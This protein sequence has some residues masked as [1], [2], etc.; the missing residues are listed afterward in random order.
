MGAMRTQTRCI[1]NAR[2]PHPVADP[3][4][5]VL[6]SSGASSRAVGQTMRSPPMSETPHPTRLHPASVSA[7]W[8]TTVT[9]LLG[10]TYGTPRPAIGRCAVCFVAAL[11]AT[12]TARAS[13]VCRFA[14]TTDYSGRIEATTNVNARVTDGT[15]TVDV[16]VHFIATPWPLVHIRY[17]MQEVSTW[18]SDQLQSVATNSRYLVD[19]HIVRQIWD[20]FDRGTN[21]LEAYRLQGKTLDDFRRKYPAF[22]RHWGAANFSQPWIQDYRLAGAER[23]PDLD[24]PA[25]SVGPDLRSPLALAFYWSRWIPRIGQAATVF[26][27]GFKKNKHLDLTFGAAEPSRYGQQVWQTS[28][29]YPAPGFGPCIDRQGLGFDGPASHATRRLRAK[30]QVCGRRCDPAG[31]LRR[32]GRGAECC[33]RIEAALLRYGQRPAGPI[34]AARL[35]VRIVFIAEIGA[36]SEAEIGAMMDACVP[37]WV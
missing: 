2:S 28:T 30:R 23:R 6:P 4:I 32:D 24:L 33:G 7:L 8:T 3:P 37:P 27:P 13:E 31:G 20:L 22:V 5:E 16:I 11:L 35:A 19:G 1:V 29:R 26:L 14:G 21:G 12:V 17:L 10:C 25:S 18:K 15:T 34:P 9:V 36:L